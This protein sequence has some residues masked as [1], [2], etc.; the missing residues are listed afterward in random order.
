MNPATDRKKKH[1]VC[2]RLVELDRDF[3][4]NPALR[5]IREALQAE[6]QSLVEEAEAAVK[7]K[8]NDRVQ[9]LLIEAEETWP[10]L[11]K[12]QTLRGRLNVDHPILRVGVRGQ[13]P[14]YF[15]PAFACTDNEHRVVEMLFESLIKR[16]PEESGSFRYR[17]GLSETP[18]KVVTLGRQF[19]LPREAVWSNG[20]QLNATDIDGSVTMLKGG[21]GVGR[22]RVWGDLFAD[23]E[24]KNDPF[25]ITLA[26]QA[27]FP[28]HIGPH[29][30]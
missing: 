3:P 16:V 12:L 7:E 25:Q 4:D 2:L 15:S 17:C 13:L 10:R 1:Q 24:S 30:L 11:P 18:P 27:G 21:T 22:L 9:Q 20:R 23:T 19:R 5:P 8:N 26:P 29:D 14:K 6:E 28:G